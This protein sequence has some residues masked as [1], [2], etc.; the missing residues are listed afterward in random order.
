MMVAHN[1]KNISIYDL[2]CQIILTTGFEYA[3][4]PSHPISG[5]SIM[6]LISIEY[7]D[8][9]KPRRL[10]TIPSLKIRSL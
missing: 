2:G 10:H 1:Q 4:Y 5:F 8:L 3:D 7:C 9:T 6:N